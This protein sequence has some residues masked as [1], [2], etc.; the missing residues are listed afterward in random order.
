M[1]R[2]VMRV[3]KRAPTVAQRVAEFL[4]R[5]ALVARALPHLLSLEATA[6]SDNYRLVPEPSSN[7]L[8]RLWK[9]TRLRRYVRCQYRC[10]PD[11]FF[12][13]RALRLCTDTF[14]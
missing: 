14:R 6:L 8:L 1:L 2:P 12:T 9:P 5:S 11:R 3:T 10:R 4:E 13:S 7:Q